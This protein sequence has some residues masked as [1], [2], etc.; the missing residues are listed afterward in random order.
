MVRKSLIESIRKQLVTMK[1]ELLSDIEEE[2][3]TESDPS[4]FEIGDIYDRAS[5]DRDRELNLILGDRD[6]EKLMEIDEALQRIEEGTYGICEEC[7]EPIGE[8]RLKVMPFAKRCVDCKALDEK[9][10]GIGRRY[11]EREFIK[12]EDLTEFEEEE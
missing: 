11:E 10:R 7:G 3:K 12:G 1:E 8:G 2:V 5:N 4:R 6:R 9:E